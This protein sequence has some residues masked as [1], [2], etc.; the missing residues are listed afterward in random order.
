[1]EKTGGML[2]Y[3]IPFYRLPEEILESEF[4]AVEK[5]GAEVRCNTRIGKDIDI[6]SLQKDYDALIITTGAW[7]PASVRTEGDDSPGVYSGIEYLKMEA[8]CKAPD[9]G[10]KTVV[11]GGGNTAIDAARTALRKG[12]ET[13]ILYRRTEKEMPANDFEIEEARHEGIAMEFLAAPLK[14]TPAAN[15]LTVRCIRMKL[16][17][18]DPS[19]RRRPVPEEGSEFDIEASSLINAVGQAAD[20]SAFADLGLEVTRWGTFKAD[21]KS[22]MTSKPGVFTAGDS[23][24]GP[25]VAVRA[26]GNGRKAAFSVCQYLDG[27]EVTGPEELFNSSMGN[28]E[29]IDPSFFSRFPKNKRIKMP[30]I[31]N[32]ERSSSFKEVESGFLPAEAV[33]EAERCLKCGCDAAEDCRLRDY[34]GRYGADGSRY[35]GARRGVETDVSHEDIKMEFHKCISCGS[36]VRACAEIKGFNVFSFVNRG[37][38]TRMRAPF[39]RSLVDTSCDGCGECVKVCPT[40]GVMSKQGR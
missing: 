15:G 11:V 1:M 18:P 19:G 10:K 16:G 8:L 24:T 26:V 13:V 38:V 30:L 34:S 37:F 5:L 6:L 32:E 17:E 2:R 22:F 21:Q 9:L 29:D 25:D 40:A 12:S 39:G 36:C 23:E 3:G 35:K 7:K 4:G 28:N 33:K 20:P 31:S 14:I 27:N